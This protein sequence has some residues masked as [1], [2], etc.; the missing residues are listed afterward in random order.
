MAASA[1]AA[2]AAP[3]NMNQTPEEKRAAR[4][5]RAAERVGLPAAGQCA[6]S[7]APVGTGTSAGTG[8]P[9]SPGTL[10]SPSSSPLLDRLPR[11]VFV[12]MLFVAAIVWGSGF[13]VMKEAVDLLKPSTL[14]GARYILAAAIMLVLTPRQ[15]VRNLQASQVLPGVALGV[16][17][18]VAFYV[19][20]QGLTDTTPGKSAFLTATY[21][22]MTPF[23]F[24][25]VGRRKP[26]LVNIVVALVAVIGIGLVSLDSGLGIGW[27]DA[28]TLLGALFFALHIALLG[29]YTKDCNVFLLTFLQFLMC[30]VLGLALGLATE[31]QPALGQVL[32]PS[33]VGQ[34]VWL[35]VVCSVVASLG[36]NVGQT[37]VPPSPAA[38]I[39]CLES[40]FGVLF[41]VLFY[42]EELTLR[43]MLGFMVIFVA[44]VLSETIGSRDG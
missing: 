39:L 37:R 19:Q 3:D 12:A 38:L 32:Q 29:R 42:G 7:E 11:W 28:L 43:I 10:A 18:F 33:I 2:E 20:T 13:F 15:I 36:Q 41:S 1:E 44:I 16:V 27:G 35:A 26:G 31:P 5:S 21:A 25:V 9:A 23:V 14:V 34:I 22:V 8:T 30:G 40:V 6:Q 4:D 24:W 17:Y